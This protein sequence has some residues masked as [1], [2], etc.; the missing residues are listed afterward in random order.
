MGPPVVKMLVACFGVL[1]VVLS[2]PLGHI[3]AAWQRMLGLNTVNETF[4]RVSYV[5]GG[6]FFLIVAL[7]AN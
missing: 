6:V 3:T 5:I 1:L 4:N 2:K 7:W